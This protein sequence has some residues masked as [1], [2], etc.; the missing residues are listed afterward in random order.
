M[1][2]LIDE[3]ARKVIITEFDKNLLVEAGAGSGKTSC[4][5]NRMIEGIKN[6]KFIVSE[7][8]AI[9]FTNKAADELKERFQ[10]ELEKNYKTATDK[11]EKLIL[12]ESLENL[13]KCFIGTVHSF[14]EKILG[15][16]P[17]EVG[18]DP[19]FN[20]VDEITEKILLQ[21]S[22]DE[23]LLKLKSENSQLLVNL[24][25][26]GIR[27]T[28]LIP[29]Y[30]ELMEYSDVNFDMKEI[31]KPDLQLTIRNIID[32]VNENIKHI[33][34]E[35]PKQGYDNLQIAIL[36]AIRILK[37]NDMYKDYSK[38]QLIE[39]FESKDIKVERWDN[40]NVANE[41]KY[42]KLPVLQQS[43]IVPALKSW[44]EYCH[45]Y[46]LSFLKAALDYY[47][48]FRH[49]E[50]II[51]FQD[52]LLKTSELLRENPEVRDYFQS[53]YKTILLDEFQDTDP[54]QA[55]V[56]FY[57]TGEDIFE[58]NWQKLIPK[59][60]SLFVV[61]DPKQSI[62]R[63]R[64][65]D[66]DV[67]NLVKK[68]IVTSGGRVLKL[69]SNFRS[70]NAIGDYLN[71]I[72]NEKLPKEANDYQASCAPL[73]TVRENQIGTDFGV[74]MLKIPKDFSKKAD[75]VKEDAEIIAKFIRNAIDNKMQLSRSKNEL[76]AGINQDARYNDFMILLRY[77]DSIEVYAK[78]LEKYGIPTRVSGGCKLGESLEVKELLTLLK[79]LGDYRNEI[80][81]VA[82]LR[83]LFFGMSDQDLYDFKD[84]DGRFNFFSEIPNTLSN[85]LKIYFKT[86]FEKLKLYY[87]WTKIYT[88]SVS[89]E[90]IM[91]DIGVFQYSLLQ[92]N[93]NSRCGELYYILESIRKWETEGI[94]DYQEMI[95]KL[96]N[97]FKYKVKEK[98]DIIGNQNVVRI[99]NL[100]KSKGLESPVVF[101]AHPKMKVS[102]KPRR[103]IKRVNGK[104]TG[105]F[106][107]SK[108]NGYQRKIIAQ[109]LNWKEYENKEKEYFVAEEVRLL[110]VAATRA[111]N[112][113]IISS[114]NKNTKNPWKDLLKYI[115]DKEVLN[116]V[117][118][119]IEDNTTLK[120]DKITLEKHNEII[121]DCNNWYKNKVTPS[122]ILTNPTEYKDVS[123][124]CSVSRTSGGGKVWGLAVH[125]LLEELVKGFEDEDL[126]IN[127]IINEYNLD[128][129]SKVKMKDI[130]RDF[131]NS[132]L[133]TRL[134]NAEVKYTEVPFSIKID[135][136]QQ[137]F[138]KLKK[139]G[140]TPI[141][142]NGVIDLI[143]KENGEWVIIDYKT[144]N[145]SSE[146]DR[147]TLKEIY[148]TQLQ[149]YQD[150]FEEITGEKVKERRLY[151][152]GLSNKRFS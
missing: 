126:I 108:P 12:K 86:V 47:Q 72:F 150:T 111:K 68:L 57:L 109:P 130:I 80:L 13:D 55:E 66:I 18:L 139:D 49:K 120:D 60:G 83:G 5:V 102:S 50:S 152:I 22:W 115:K 134:Q 59:P 148:N 29:S 119:S 129:G 2:N 51:N 39:L 138:Y 7:T 125:K 92:D 25:K 27:V 6:K 142:L 140:S 124:I 88:P 3:G 17:V 96:E 37:F 1:S 4:L 36:T 19:Q 110:Y 63:F 101:L 136:E 99:M 45:Y 43:Y 44:R 23:F 127:R 14:C 144:D 106:L 74:K 48:F 41:L 147:N 112:M 113:L 61:G 143:F 67:Y 31:E 69:I 26:I 24:E 11:D 87:K 58:K 52:L 65:A 94:T 118:V 28:D 33:P 10:N 53:K 40:I 64:R 78:A 38:I 133:W 30:N 114:E 107:I 117:D 90:K 116:I 34:D 75:V 16:R 76:K 54:I 141:I 132:D 20:E 9:T 82:T 81:N 8:V 62:Y 149:I 103:H 77:T 104:A 145:V 70:L 146:E 79:L 95:I 15:E 91:I 35:E 93:G 98:L 56:V 21:N 32:F 151:F 123:T 100:H 46:T 122:Y 137:L 84:K 85:E 131:K 42:T 73:E 105:Y 89:V 121:S 97:L 135:E 128:T 71:D